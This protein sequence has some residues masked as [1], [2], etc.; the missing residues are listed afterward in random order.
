M[1]ICD[2]CAHK[3]DERLLRR[4]WAD[5]RIAS[6]E[7]ALKDT[8]LKLKGSSAR[9]VW[10]SAW[11]TPSVCSKTFARPKPSSAARQDIFAVEDEIEAQRD[12]LIAALQKRLHRAS[13]NQSLFTVCWSVV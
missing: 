8:K 6:A 12:A 1:Q 13:R 10:H 11:K 5:D 3:M 4:A 2:A 7:Q 9:P